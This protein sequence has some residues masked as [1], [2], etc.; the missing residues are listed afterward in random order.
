MIYRFEAR[1]EGGVKKLFMLCEEETECSRRTVDLNMV[2]PEV[3]ELRSFNG[4]GYDP[5]IKTLVEFHQNAIDV[6]FKHMEIK[7]MGGYG[8]GMKQ[9][10][11]HL[12]SRGMKVV[13][14][15]TPMAQPE[16]YRSSSGVSDEGR[17]LWFE[18][19][20]PDH[21]TINSF[22]IGYSEKPVASSYQN[23]ID[24]ETWKHVELLK[25]CNGSWRDT[26]KPRSLC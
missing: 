4:R 5:S 24:F 16:C 18:N 1:H 8:E 12:I 20:S 2:V 26:E 9:A 19:V 17:M 10:L 3:H 23:A 13:I 6:I 11:V 21:I 7:E 14:E 15:V 25:F 22:I